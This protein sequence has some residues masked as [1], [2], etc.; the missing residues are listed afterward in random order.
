MPAA[1][2]MTDLFLPISPF[3]LPKTADSDDRLH[4]LTGAGAA[5]DARDDQGQQQS[6]CRRSLLDL[7]NDVKGNL[8]EKS[9]C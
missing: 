8:E 9:R 4:R 2:K 5:S 6:C 3:E 1:Q 7:R